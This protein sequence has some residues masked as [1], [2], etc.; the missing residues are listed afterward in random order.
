MRWTP[1]GLLAV[2]CFEQGAVTLCVIIRIC[3]TSD[4]LLVAK[5]EVNSDCLSKEV[6]FSVDSEDPDVRQ[7]YIHFKLSSN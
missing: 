1:T 7:P 5:T 6:G 3:R 2:L 4:T